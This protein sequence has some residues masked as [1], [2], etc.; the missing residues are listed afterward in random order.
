MSLFGA[1][2]IFLCSTF[3][4]IQILNTDKI[5]VFNKQVNFYIS[6]ALFVWFLVTTP[7]DFY[8]IYFLNVDWD[9]IFLKWEIYLFA[10]IFMYSTFT[11]ALIYCKPENNKIL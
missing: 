3:Y 6:I 8:H 7:L 5:L 1:L 10:N 11:F 4:F 2:I 9:F